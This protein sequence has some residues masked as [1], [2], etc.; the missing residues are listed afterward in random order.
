MGP[1]P[2]MRIDPS[3]D[4]EHEVVTTLRGFR[5]ATSIEG[6]LTGRGAWYIIIDDPLKPED[7]FS[8]TSREAVNRWFSSTF[9]SRLDS[10]TEGV[11]IIVM[12]R[13]HVN[14][15]VGHVL[16]QG[17][18]TVLRLPAFA[19]IAED[20]AI[21]LGRV[22]HREPGDVPRPAHEP[23]SELEKARTLLGSYQFSAQYQQNPLPA[24]GGLIDWSWFKSYD[25]APIKVGGDMIIQSWDTAS[26][27]ASKA[28]EVNDFSVCTTW[29][30]RGKD[31]YLIKVTRNQLQ[32]PQLKAMAID[33]AK[34]HC[35]SLKIRGRTDAGPEATTL[36]P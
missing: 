1:F 23:R 31:S 19:E 4:T 6:T 34:R 14:D 10:K 17:G 20:V 3:K 18:W 13:L 8:E 9:M 28:E 21:G 30:R 35:R 5:F 29:L 16:E 33:M 15:L 26:K 11:I 27:A 22:H 36:E 12:Q 2:G 24:E 7:A 32:Y 25:Q